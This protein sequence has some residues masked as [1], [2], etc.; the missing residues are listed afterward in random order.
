MGSARVFSWFGD[1]TD[2]ATNPAG[3]VATASSAGAAP[4]NGPLLRAE[5]RSFDFATDQTLQF[6]YLLPSNYVSG[7][8]LTFQYSTAATS[9][10]VIFKTA[11]VLLNPG[12]T[13]W[14]V[15]S[16]GTVTS[17]AAN[18]VP[19]TA[20]I[21]KTVALDLGGERRGCRL[22]ARRRVRP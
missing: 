9:G 5:T 12:T 17:A 14:D 1:E 21:R 4:T 11:Y 19:A 10:N 16:F 15:A 22:R 18:A 13:D 20:G 6:D 2:P 3:A 7:G 8:T